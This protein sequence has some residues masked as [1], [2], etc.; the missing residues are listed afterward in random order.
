MSTSS[1]RQ[2]EL[3]K[4]YK[5]IELLVSPEENRL[6]EQA[7]KRH[8]RPKTRFAK[9]AV[10]AY[11]K[12]MYI[13]PDEQRLQDLELALKRIGTN[14]NQVAFVCNRNASVL[15]RDVVELKYHLQPLESLIREAF[16]RPVNLNDLVRAAL[17]EHPRY[18]EVLE[19]IIDQESSA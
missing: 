5:R 7:A 2:R 4:R 17:K 8:K 1:E 14:V 6:I 11:L 15:E 3:R 10:I 9:D 16:A 12:G 19:Q 13:V 18:R